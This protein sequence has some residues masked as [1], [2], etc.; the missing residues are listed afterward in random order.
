MRDPMHRLT[1]EIDSPHSDRPL[2]SIREPRLLDATEADY[3]L[4]NP[5]LVPDP[6]TVPELH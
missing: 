6:P 5:T 2:P 4:D 3:R 1:R